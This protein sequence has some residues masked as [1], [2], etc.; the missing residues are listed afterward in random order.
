[1]LGVVAAAISEIVTG[2]TVWSQIAGKYIDGE[3]VEKAHGTSFLYF[4]AIVVIFTMASLA[5]TLLVD[6]EKKLKPVDKE[7]GPFKA[8][9]EMLNG[10]A[11]MLGFAALL[12]VELFKQSPIF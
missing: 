4:A 11:A 9:A 7:F 2:Q 1:M 8:S 10:R 5:P 3:V 12:A 6:G